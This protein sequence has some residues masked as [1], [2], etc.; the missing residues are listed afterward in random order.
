MKNK[1]HIALL[2]FL[3]L[4]LI[5]INN[6]HSQDIAD[7][8]I[9]KPYSLIYAMS[10]SVVIKNAALENGRYTYKFLENDIVVDIKDN[11]YYEYHSNNEFVKAKIDWISE[12][13]YKLTIIGMERREAPFKI[14][15]TLSAE[16]TKID[17]INY[18]YNSKLNGKTAK[19]KFKKI[20]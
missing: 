14:G 11:L 12:Y 15:T 20:Y 16:I 8:K 13:E 1:I 5:N 9:L 3:S 7:S 4:S 18:Y 6:I 17:G 2:L 19:G 10:N